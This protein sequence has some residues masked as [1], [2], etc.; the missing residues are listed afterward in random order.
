MKL[1]VHRFASALIVLA[2]TLGGVAAAAAQQTSSSSEMKKFTI[3]SVNGNKVVAKDA[4]GTH[5]YTLPADFKFDVGGKQIGVSDLKPGMTGTAT[6]TTTTTVTPVT[7]TEVRNGTVMQATGNSLIVR[8]PTGIKMFSTADIQKR[9]A[10]LMKDGKPV[11]FSDLHTDDRL[12]ATIVTDAPPKVM[13][14]REVQATIAEAAGTAGAAPPPAART[15]NADAGA[16]AS[17]V[18]AP[19]AEARRLPKTGS[20]LP[21]LGLTGVALFALA[22]GLTMVRRRA[23][24]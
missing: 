17:N 24:L 15:T 6:I 19:A 16:A 21:L 23:E 18:P 9:N 14:S 4:T 22:A 13:T 8:T 10:T 20:S 1:T 5:E 12:S 11:D 3:V 7:V 2:L